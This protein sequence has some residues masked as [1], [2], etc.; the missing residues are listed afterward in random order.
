MPLHPAVDEVWA[1][2]PPSVAH[3]YKRYQA[4]DDAQI[5]TGASLV[6]PHWRLPTVLVVFKASGF[7]S[8]GPEA[9]HQLH[10]ALRLAGIP[11]V[12]V[13]GYHPYRTPLSH[14]S[15]EMP[16]DT[17]RRGDIVVAGE[18]TPLPRRVRAR[19]ARL[20]VRFVT[21]YL[22]QVTPDLSSVPR[23][24]A[25]L[26]ISHYFSRMYGCAHAAV[27]PVP[28]SE[29]FF[30]TTPSG[31]ERSRL[32][33]QIVVIDSDTSAHV[34]GALQGELHTAHFVVA[35]GIPRAQLTA[36]LHAATVVVDLN[37]PGMERLALEGVLA[38]ACGVFGAAGQGRSR[39]DLPV[40]SGYIVEPHDAR[41][42]VQAVRQCLDDYPNESARFDRLRHLLRRD[43]ELFPVRAAWLFT[44]VATLVLDV[45]HQLDATLAMATML[46][47]WAAA[48]LVRVLIRVSD[49]ESFLF[50][51]AAVI[52]A[53]KLIGLWDAVRIKVVGGG[54]LTAVSDSTRA[55]AYG[56]EAELDTAV[57]CFGLVG[58]L[59]SPKTQRGEHPHRLS[60]ASALCRT[61][62]QGRT[63]G[64]TVH[65]EQALGLSVNLVAGTRKELCSA[66]SADA[67]SPLH[68]V[69]RNLC[70]MDMDKI[71]V[72]GGD[73]IR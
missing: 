39:V 22:G 23:N 21:Y 27:L 26:C 43:R 17:I 30:R 71:G 38:G 59:F 13:H 29:W 64:S 25:P 28:M 12:M 35:S 15:A 11:T 10:H 7:A 24:G 14:F 48:P 58:S 2:V 32:G 20:G 16:W 1:S 3:F 56:W 9:L 61:D 19:L 63:G 8:G 47:A 57:A 67:P 33:Y 5:A 34:T 40:P 31:T 36:L 37:L 66:V 68:L 69:Q 65:V 41:A 70:F 4:I 55:V 51:V 49:R 45:A 53:L 54:S 62:S 42:A 50:E 60:A 52:E 6:K 46:S 73:T 44:R 18:G 72:Q